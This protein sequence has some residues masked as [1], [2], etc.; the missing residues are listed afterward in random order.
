MKK[1]LFLSTI[2]LAL[3]VVSCKPKAE[4]IVG[5]WSVSECSITNLEELKSKS[6]TGVPDSLIEEYKGRMEGQI[7]T[8]LE[9][10]KKEVY[11]FEKDSFDINRHGKSEL[12][13]WKMSSDNKMLFLILNENPT[14]EALNIIGLTP[15]EV[16][17]SK[18]ISPE[19][20][21][22]YILKKD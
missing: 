22:V 16:K 13:S 15:K 3:L 4:L 20:A 11:S 6:M 18:K 14:V 8:F 19:S 2:A 5:K 10:A 21:V 12:G 17:F 7:K 1:L 9:D